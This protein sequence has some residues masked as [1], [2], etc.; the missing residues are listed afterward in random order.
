M[1][2]TFLLLIGGFVAAV[3]N[4]LA[5]GGS[6]ITVPLLVVAGAPGTVA[7]GTNRVGVLAGTFNA[8]RMFQKLGVE[9]MKGIGGIL[10]P[11]VAGS[12]LG[13]VVVSRLADDAFE[14]VFGVLMIPIL[15]LSLRKPNA[16]SLAERPPWPRWLS[17]GV[18]F[19]VGLYG[20]AF[21]AGVG[22]LLIV[23]LARSGVDLVL[24]NH[25]KVITTFVFTCFA[26]P[27]FLLDG[28]IDWNLALPLSVGFAGGAWVGAHITVA[29]GERVV[30][31]VLILAV[32]ALSGR[33]VGL[34]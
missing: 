23:A 25:I 20:G 28:R 33:L 8:S 34:Y 24:A 4:T 3:I 32:V 7:N 26:L 13:S 21:Q 11:A 12:I 27:V 6:L 15:L 16:A 29:G 1:S 14:Q 22:L 17:T 18:F 19:A 30:R 10:G 9:G 31:P 5:G 2:D